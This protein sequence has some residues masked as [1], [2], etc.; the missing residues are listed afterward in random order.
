M[1]EGKSFHLQAG[2]VSACTLLS[3]CPPPLVRPIR[4]F[5][6]RRHAQLPSKIQP[7]PAEIHGF[8]LPLPRQ[9]F[10][11]QWDRFLLLFVGVG[12][13]GEL[14]ILFGPVSRRHEHNK[15][16]GRRVC[17]LFTAKRQ[18]MGVRLW[19]STHGNLWY[20]SASL[21]SFFKALT[22]HVRAHNTRTRTHAHTKHAHSKHTLSTHTKHTLSTHTKHPLS[23]RTKHTLRTHLANTHAHTRTHKVHTLS[24]NTHTLSTHTHR[25]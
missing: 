23:T 16:H 3:S 15:R 2:T 7:M 6:L 4:P 10:P 17:L 11:Y 21:L 20:C 5:F 24:T 18:E 8:F 19:Y 12:F 14:A 9:T 1:R 25:D 13:V 22:K